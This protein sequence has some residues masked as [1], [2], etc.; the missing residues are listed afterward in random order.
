MFK[1]IDIIR[2]EVMLGIPSAANEQRYL[3]HHD[4]KFSSND[5]ISQPTTRPYTL[6]YLE[7]QKRVVSEPTFTVARARFGCSELSV[8]VPP[9][10]TSGSQNPSKSTG[11]RSAYLD[12][13]G[14][15]F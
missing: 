7:D 5:A 15:S 4:I 10:A 1:E 6:V 13:S 2:E 3:H 14:P 11:A 12:D 8:S 9:S